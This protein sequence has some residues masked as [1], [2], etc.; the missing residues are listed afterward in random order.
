[1]FIQTFGQ[2]IKGLVLEVYKKNKFSGPPLINEDEYH[3]SIKWS[4]F[5]I[6]QQNCDLLKLK[7]CNTQTKRIVNHLNRINNGMLNTNLAGC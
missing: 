5:W 2:W 1:M 3:I 4:T 6:G 7:L